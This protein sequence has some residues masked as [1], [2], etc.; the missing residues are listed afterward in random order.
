MICANAGHEFP[1]IYHD[2]QFELYKD[3]HGLVLGGMNGISYKD[4]E[5]TLEKGD[6]I[7]VYTDGVTEAMNSNNELFGTD[8]MIDALNTIDEADPKVVLDAV[9]KSVNKFVGP[10]EQFDDL[11]MVC[12][13]YIGSVS[14]D[15]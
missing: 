7:F 10:A 5:L 11:T 8:R 1:A 6:M 9:H 15:F 13:K 4:Y 12:L 3:R 14:P 2:G